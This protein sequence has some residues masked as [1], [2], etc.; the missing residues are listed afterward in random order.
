MLD[1]L[2]RNGQIAD[3]QSVTRGSIG[4]AGGR[5]AARPASGGGAEV[6][7]ALPVAPRSA[8]A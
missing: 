6:E 2:I 1:L 4:V 8:R 5:I 7:I 3:S